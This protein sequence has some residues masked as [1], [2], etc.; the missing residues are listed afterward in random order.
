MST[1]PPAVKPAAPIDASMT[2]EQAQA[3]LETLI[4]R[5]EGGQVGLEESMVAYERGVALLKHCRGILEKAEQTFTDLS[6]KVN[7]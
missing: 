6:E 3:E 7:G 4:T 1:K 2:F 5:I